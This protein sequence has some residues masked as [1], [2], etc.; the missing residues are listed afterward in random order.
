MTNQ[1]NKLV[2]DSGILTHLKTVAALKKHG[3]SL[4]ISSYYYDNVADLVKEIDIVAEKQFNSSDWAGNSSIQ[5]NVQ[6][7]IE[8]KY[9]D[10]EIVVWF[11]K[12]NRQKAIKKLEQNSGLR[13]ADRVSGDIIPNDF[14]Y[15]PTDKVAKLFSANANK[16][17]VF[18]KAISQCLRAQVYYEQWAPG[19]ISNPFNNHN[20][21]RTKIVRYP[22]VICDN[23]K[24]I[25]EVEV[26][27]QSGK[28]ITKDID[29]SF[30]LET[31]YVYFNKDKTATKDDYF[32]IDFVG[33]DTLDS[34]LPILDK[35]ATSVVN[36]MSFLQRR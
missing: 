16:D 14:H 25:K 24:N 2:E 18:Y 13:I 12:M 22:I 6:L 15:L 34:W 7:F 11:D 36:S 4:N 10:K 28:F 29:E 27:Q 31:N 5:V 33:I 1:T 23:F 9:I 26:N 35:E 3:W 8:C 20:E 21:V 17:D 19:P 32:L 30:L